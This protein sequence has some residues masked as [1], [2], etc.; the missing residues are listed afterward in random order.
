VWTHHVQ[1]RSFLTDS[2]FRENIVFGLAE[3]SWS[4][5]KGIQSVFLKGTSA[6][7]VANQ[8]GQIYPSNGLYIINI[9][10]N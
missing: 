4:F 10:K 5:F 8:Y 1:S 6:S 2:R 7:G 3:N 9:L